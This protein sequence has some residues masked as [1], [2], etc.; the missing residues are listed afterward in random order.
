[1]TGEKEQGYTPKE[2][3]LAVP[4]AHKQHLSLGIPRELA[5]DERRLALRPGAVQVLVNNGFEVLIEKGA[6]LRSN[7]DDQEYA[8]AGARI[9]YSAQDAFK[10]DIV[11][12]IGMPA[13]EEL[14]YMQTGR[15]LL[16][17]MHLRH[18]SREQLSVISRKRLNCLAFDL[19]QDKAEGLPITRAMSEIAGSTVMSIAAEYL[20]SFNN[21]RGV[22]MGGI[23][24]VPP[25]KVVILGAGTVAEYAARIALGMGAEVKVFDAH[26][27]RLSRLKE[28]L[29]YPHLYTSVFD[30]VAFKEAISRADVAI[31]AIHAQEGVCPCVVTEEM[32]SSMKQNSVIIDVSID[33]G[34]CFETS[35]ETSHSIPVYKKYGV[36]HYC[37][38]NIPSRVSRTATAALS[39]ILSPIL[40]KIADAGTVDRMML[41]HPWFAKGVYAYRG[42]VTYKP[43]SDAFGVPWKNLDLILVSGLGLGN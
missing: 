26:I 7:H 9:V 18:M 11:L 42:G 3:L 20:N 13:A 21:G 2:Q 14:E 28:R 32:V 33:Q 37:V 35:Q 5:E 36:I 15:T 10:A 29:G 12:K 40:L 34:G 16:S 4:T 41:E 27:Y 38:P 8:E 24:G 1:M 19:I 43:L 6:G 39:N 17:A 31:G 23:T 25:S 30:N 22:I